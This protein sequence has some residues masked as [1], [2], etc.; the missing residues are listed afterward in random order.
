MGFFDSFS[1]L[2]EAAL[3]WSSAEA[4]AQ[5]EEED[6]DVTVCLLSCCA[7]AVGGG[8]PCCMQADGS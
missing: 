1:D 8:E 5:K 2:L 7:R 6:E 4:E 3:P